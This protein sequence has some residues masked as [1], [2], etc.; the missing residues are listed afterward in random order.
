[1]TMYIPT[2]PGLAGRVALVTGAN[3][4]IGAASALVLAT[5]GAKVLLTY[6]RLHDEPD[7]AVPDAYATNRAR[8]AHAVVESIRT[9]GGTAE[10]VECDL[11]DPD[12]APTLFDMAERLFG[13]VEILINNASGWCADT[14]TLAAVDPIGRHTSQVSQMSFDRIFDVDA[15]AAALL[16]SEFARRH[17]QG[18]ATWGRII[19]MTSGGPGGFP[20]EVSYGAAKAAQENLTMAAARELA[21]KGVTA[22]MV[23]PP[24]TDTGW[25]TDEVREAVRTSTDHVHVAHPDEVAAVIAYLASDLGRLVTA[26]VLHL[27]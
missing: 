9:A 11:A 6:L 2:F 17:I 8:S 14:F 24:V 12:S 25:V 15:R 20:G 27:R 3:H 4:G 21:D 26:N 13:P 19:G 7:P 18:G 22:N 10:A 5:Q 23:Y 1:M 16:I